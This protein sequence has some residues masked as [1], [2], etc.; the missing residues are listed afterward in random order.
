MPIHETFLREA[1]LGLQKELITLQVE[2]RGKV[3]ADTRQS[4]ARATRFARAVYSLG[5]NRFRNWWVP[6]RLGVSLQIRLWVESVIFSMG[7][8][9][10]ELVSG[11]APLRTP[12]GV[13]KK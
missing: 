13:F 12:L 5:F 3:R 11:F 10:S 1:S 6:A 8:P 4:K 7:T 9:W 2:S